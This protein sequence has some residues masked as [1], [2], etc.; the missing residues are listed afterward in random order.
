MSHEEEPLYH[1]IARVLKSE[2]WGSA[3]YYDQTVYYDMASTLRERQRSTRF[4]PEEIQP[5]SNLR[6]SLGD[7]VECNCGSWKLG[8]VAN[9]LPGSY[10]ILLDEGGATI[11]VSDDVHLVRGPTRSRSL[12]GDPN[13]VTGIPDRQLPMLGN[14][15]VLLSE[16]DAILKQRLTSPTREQTP[17]HMTWLSLDPRSERHTAHEES[18]RRIQSVSSSCE[19]S[20]CPSPSPE[21]RLDVDRRY[22]L[23]D[24]ADSH[25]AILESGPVRNVSPTNM[26]RRRKERPHQRLD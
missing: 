9:I 7:Q 10:E 4:N 6:F 24:G 5:V 12:L 25:R 2:P 3:P 18:H 8:H 22:E 1:D 26:A 11:T 21:Q 14:V 19:P 13:L 17:A 23:M 20:A 16:M 15:D